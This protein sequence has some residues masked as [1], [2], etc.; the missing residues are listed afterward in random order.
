[1]RRSVSNKLINTIIEGLIIFIGLGWMM[2]YSNIWEI[3]KLC[4]LHIWIIILAIGG[5][6]GISYSWC[7]KVFSLF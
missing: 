4:G 1:M 6:L 7:K 5:I 2:G 3:M